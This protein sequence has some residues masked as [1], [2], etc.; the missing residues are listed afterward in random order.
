MISGKDMFKK[1]VLSIDLDYIMEPSIKKYNELYFNLNSKMRWEQLYNNTDYDENSFDIDE[2]NFLFCF[3]IFCKSMMNCKNVTFGYDHDEILYSIKKW[4][5][6]DIINIDWH[7]DIIEGRYF[8][9]Y[10][11]IVV[12]ANREYCD[13]QNDEVTEGNWGAWLNAKKKLNSFTWICGNNSGSF[14]KNNVIKSLMKEKLNF[15]HKDDYVFKNYKF[16]HIFVCLSPQYIPPKYWPRFLIFLKTYQNFWKTNP[17]LLSGKYN[18][19]KFEKRHLEVESV[20][21]QYLNLC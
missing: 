17:K 9:F 15:S 19:N 14:E 7:D 4:S 6:I 2:K 5:N 21:K 13:I 12:A 20:I 1:R 8:G 18:R 11:N 10:N 3:D 16:D